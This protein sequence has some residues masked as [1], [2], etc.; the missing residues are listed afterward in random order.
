M[1]LIPIFEILN[2][3]TN[4]LVD[5]KTKK[6]YMICNFSLCF[7]YFHASVNVYK[8]N[9][10]LGQKYPLPSLDKFRIGLA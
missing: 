10:D 1:A 4:T 2:I 7:F 8:S 9:F 3:V 5:K 6:V